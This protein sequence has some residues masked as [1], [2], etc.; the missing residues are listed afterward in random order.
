MINQLDGYTYLSPPTLRTRPTL[1]GVLG[2]LIEIIEHL[3][4]VAEDCRAKLDL[5]SRSMINVPGAHERLLKEF[6]LTTELLVHA[7]AWLATST[8]MLS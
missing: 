7:N 5:N 6:V 3:D 4:V 8:E 1:V 2:E